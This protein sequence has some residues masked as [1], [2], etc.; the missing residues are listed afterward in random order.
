MT[1]LRFSNSKVRLSSPLHPAG[2]QKALSR[3]DTWPSP[4]WQR[5]GHCPVKPCIDWP[6]KY[7]GFASP[8]S[9]PPKR[10]SFRTLQGISGSRGGTWHFSK[11]TQISGP[12]SNTAKKLLCLGRAAFPLRFYITGSSQADFPGCRDGKASA[13]NAGD[14]GSILGLGRSSGEGNGNPLQYSCLENPM[15]REVW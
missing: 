8:Q 14:P 15:D 4:R 11:S 2:Q 7:R 3:T 9:W 5:K 6:G 13:Y 1:L 10:R 12:L